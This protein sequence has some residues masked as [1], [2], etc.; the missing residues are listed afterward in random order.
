M[1]PAL[2]A[3]RIKGG[4]MQTPMNMVTPQVSAGI[5]TVLVK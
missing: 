5:T 2:A 4:D 1:S 3:V